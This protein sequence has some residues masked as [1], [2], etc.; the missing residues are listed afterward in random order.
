MLALLLAAFLSASVDGPTAFAPYTLGRYTADIEPDAAVSWLVLSGTETA[1]FDAHDC[2]MVFT[3]KPG[4]YLIIMS[5]F[6]TDENGKPF[7]QQI[8]KSVDITD[9]PE[10]G[11]DPNPPTPPVPPE[12][13]PLPD[14][15][16]K[17]AAWAFQSVQ[18][19]PAEDK[20]KA[21]ALGTAFDSLASQ[22]DAGAFPWNDGMKAFLQATA[23][24]VKEQGGTWPQWLVT[25]KNQIA[26]LPINAGKDCADAWREIAIGLKAVK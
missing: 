1:D 7:L 18:G 22:L 3:G 17:L 12:P 5:T 19:M 6:G 15:K 8:T 20:A 21:V 4:R 16:Y 13:T 11:P 14:G 25:L 26:S 9:G 10:P 2:C 23:A 24:K